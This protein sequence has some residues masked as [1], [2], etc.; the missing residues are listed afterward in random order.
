MDVG[1]LA[2]GQECLEF[3]GRRR[4]LLAGEGGDPVGEAEDAVDLEGELALAQGALLDGG[5]DSRYQDA[6]L[7]RTWNPR[8]M[9]RGPACAIPPKRSRGGRP[10]AAPRIALA[11]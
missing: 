5:I 9:S 8:A 3:G 1:G 10:A 4:G 2:L 11:G 7:L 6:M